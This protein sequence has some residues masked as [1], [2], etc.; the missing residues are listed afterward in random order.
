MNFMFSRKTSTFWGGVLFIS[1]VV[2]C[3]LGP[4]FS[5][6]DP[7]TPQTTVEHRNAPPSKQHLFGTDKFGRDVL[8]RVL[9]GG[10]LSLGIGLGVVGL[11]LFV[12]SFYGAVAGYVGGRIDYAMMRVLDML[13][14]FP[15][16]FLAVTCMA[17]FGS[18]IF[19]LIV[20]LALTSWM[21]IARLVRAEIHSLK[22]RAMTVRAL[23]SGLNTRTIVWK[24]LLPNTFPTL[25]AVAVV[26]LADVIL[27][28]SSLSFIG[29]GVQPPMASWGAI[30]NDGRMSF[31]PAWWV[32][33]FPGLAIILTTLSLHLIGDGVKVEN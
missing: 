5:P 20:I 4:L 13:L 33:V 32:S 11:S 9:V 21:D 14:S 10:R 22:N 7:D 24:H 30:I 6:Y 1:L 12:G 16:I 15:L 17:L 31:A 26:R 27:I 2:A 23:A 29:L 19:Y 18:G 8:A 28:E 25:S 3:L